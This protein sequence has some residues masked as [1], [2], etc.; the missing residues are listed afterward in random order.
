MK[1]RETTAVNLKESLAKLESL[2]HEKRPAFNVQHGAGTPEYA[3][4]WRA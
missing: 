2:G 1:P 4:A 3:T